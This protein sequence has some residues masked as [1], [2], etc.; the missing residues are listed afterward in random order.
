MI[1]R[2]VRER[3]PE[4]LIDICRNSLKTTGYEDLSLLS[5]STG[6]YT[7]L[8]PL[9]ENLMT[10]CEKDRVAISL[11]SIRAGTL[12]PALMR[13]IRKIRKTGFTIAPEAGSQ[14]LRNVINKN[15]TYDDI[16]NTV[17]DAFSLGWK[18]IK[19]YFMIGLPTETEDDIAAI[20]QLVN[21]LKRIKSVGNKRGR[22]NIS[23]TSFIP[24][25]HTPFQWVSQISMAHSKRIIDQLKNEFHGTSVHLK[26]Q[27][28][29]MSILEGALARGDRRLS[30]VIYQAWKSHCLFD[31]WTDHFNY[32]KW[33]EAFSL[34]GVTMD[35]FTIRQRTQ[36][37][38]LPWQHMD[39][40][41]SLKFLKQQREAALNEEGLSDCRHDQCHQCGACDFTTTQPQLF[42]DCPNTEL[43][44]SATIPPAIHEN[45]KVIVK[46]LSYS[47]LEQARFFGHLELAKIFARA[48]RRAAI[49]VAYSK[50]FHPMPRMSF[51]DPLPLGME[52]ECEKFR[53]H[54]ET[55]IEDTKLIE[56]LNE[57]LPS[58]LW[59]YSSQ[60]HTKSVASAEPGFDSYR[61]SLGNLFLDNER[62]A[63]FF[64]QA[65]WPYDKKRAKGPSRP[66]DLRS[67]V[68]KLDFIKPDVLQLIIYR[69][70]RFA[71][72][73]SDVLI[74]V[75]GLHPEQLSQIRVRKTA[76][77]SMP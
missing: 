30:Q 4:T 7:C 65:Q 29:S 38:P 35:E 13:M 70:N 15:I 34:A 71:V 64:N 32:E 43:I 48:M 55:P 40:R 66:V 8:A 14:R 58:G 46:E 63:D 22:L 41:V 39:T 67:V 3:S 45:G 60:T 42:K 51:D 76:S 5:L 59:I 21:D 62:L 56:K 12:T 49:D 20:V 10:I 27:H 68:K 11:P 24:K 54:L 18:V 31:G 17:E 77:I 37:E 57:Q 52:S 33:V 44:C 73:P 69:N 9:M 16:A 28:P 53:I 1:Y 2:P 6:D 50:G 72:R 74:S 61:I 23:V 47:K 19:L 75:F 25:P 36:D 26:W